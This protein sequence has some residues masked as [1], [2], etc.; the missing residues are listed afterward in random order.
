MCWVFDYSLSHSCT[1]A[2]NY[3]PVQHMEVRFV[4]NDTTN[5][6]QCISI[7]ILDDM[8]TEVTNYFNASITT[9]DAGVILVE[10][11]TCIIA[12]MNSDCELSNL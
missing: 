9:Y 7:I 1:G 11:K 4:E 12:V 2:A 5:S 10:P 6:T 8:I 3:S